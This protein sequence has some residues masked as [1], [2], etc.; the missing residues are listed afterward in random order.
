MSSII[1]QNFGFVLTDPRTRIRQRP[2]IRANWIG[3]F[4]TLGDEAKSERILVF[5]VLSVNYEPSTTRCQQIP[6]FS[7]IFSLIKY[8]KYEIY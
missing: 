2:F 8:V 4:S 7:L 1:R 6:H 5:L 3:T